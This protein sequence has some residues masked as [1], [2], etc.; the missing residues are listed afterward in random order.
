MSCQNITTLNT[1][2]FIATSFLSPQ[3][4]STPLLYHLMFSL[5]KTRFVNVS[6]YLF[7][8]HKLQRSITINLSRRRPFKSITFEKKKLIALLLHLHAV[9]SQFFKILCLRLAA[10][11]FTERQWR[12]GIVSLIHDGVNMIFAY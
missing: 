2:N 1:Q 5:L 9:C 12:H 8:Q 3:Y 6:A 4:L 7:W 10:E 11:I